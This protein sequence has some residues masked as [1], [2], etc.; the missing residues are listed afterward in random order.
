VQKP[1]HLQAAPTEPRVWLQRR[2][3]GIAALALG[4][5]TFLVVAISQHPIFSEP[6]ARISIPGFTATLIAA[7][8]SWGRREHAHAYW[9]AGL[10]LA[11]AALVLGWFLMLAIVIGATAVL[12]AILHV[13]L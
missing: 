9:L 5:L 7:L 11:A 13:V 8:F 12:I 3:A 10:G 4:L 1:D 2:A 6:D